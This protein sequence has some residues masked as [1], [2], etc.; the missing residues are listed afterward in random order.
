M[1]VD[2]EEGKVVGGLLGVVVLENDWVR[3][4]VLI[5][6]GMFGGYVLGVGVECGMGVDVVLCVYGGELF[7]GV[8]CVGGDEG[9]GE[10]EDCVDGY[11]SG[12]D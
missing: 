5:E 3:I 9:M 2:V 7:V 8:C 11:E 6:G 10:V 1:G 12:E 4:E